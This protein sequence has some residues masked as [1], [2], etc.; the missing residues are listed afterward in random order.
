M[1][2]LLYLRPQPEAVDSDTEA[3]RFDWV[4]LDAAGETLGEGTDEPRETVENALSANRID[5][6]RILGLIPAYEVSHCSARIPARQTRFIQQALPFAVEEQVAQDIED[7]HLA[8]GR[9]QG[10]QWQ[11]AAI[12]RERMA[13]YQALF[14]SWDYP[15][16]GIYADAGLLPT[17]QS[18]WSALVCDEHVLVAGSEGEWF[19]VPTEG[20]SVFMDSLVTDSDPDSPPVVRLFLSPREAEERQVELAAL[21]QNP[22]IDL[23]Q[24]TLDISELA[25]LARTHHQHSK[26]ALNL[27]QGDFSLRDQSESPLRRWRAVAVVAALGLVLQLGLMAADGYYHYQRA[28]AYEAR[29]VALYQDIFPSDTRVHAGNLRANLAGR[30]RAAEQ[31][32]SQAEY[33]ALLRHAGYQYNQLESP[34]KV[35]FESINFSRQR[36]ELVMELRGDSFSRL[37]R[38]RSGLNEAGLQARIGSVVN[39]DDHTRGR[40]TV[41]RGGS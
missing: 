33:L 25:F 17:D 21:G 34:D 9:R 32:G 18:R 35:R 24:V 29:A 28:E 37:D 2:Y 26:A 41:S 6:P 4:L 20:L 36:G 1:S 40:I 10:D 39:E 14:R 16:E 19:D 11:V 3:P 13:A 8:V 5:H 31:G 22:E 27:C 23:Q 7:M 12:D 15:L 38:I 30:L